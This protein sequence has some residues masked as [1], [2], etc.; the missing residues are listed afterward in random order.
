MRRIVLIGDRGQIGWELARTLAPLGELLVIGRKTSP[1]AIEL[2]DFDSIRRALRE[3]S[4]C[5]V[6]N[7]AAYTAVDQAEQEQDTATAVNA[8][9][10]GILAEEAGRTGS[11]L[12]H[13]STDYVFDGAKASPYTEEDPVQPLNVYGETKLAGER[14]IAAVAPAYVILR[15]SWVYGLRG[16]NFLRTIMCLAKERDELN[17]VDDQIGCPTWSRLIA[18]ATA[19]MLS[20]PQLTDVL[21]TG[22]TYHLVASG[23]TSWHGFA[24][25]IVAR[26]HRSEVRAKAVTA[27][28]SDAY[29]QAAQR[30]KNSTL[31]TDL[32]SNTFGIRL[33]SWQRGLELCLDD[34]G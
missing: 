23:R 16:G 9:A 32:L 22:A 7:A 13:Y 30:P 11:L 28:S 17:V 33:P 4:P 26:M 10:P 15:T 21:A 18:E 34:G 19:Q 24:D 5:I 8:I 27:I 3:L 12:V 31:C 6:V 1:V 2:T 14:A 25:A 20:R 29:P